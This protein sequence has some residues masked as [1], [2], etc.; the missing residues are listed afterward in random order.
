MPNLKDISHRQQFKPDSIEHAYR[1]PNLDDSILRGLLV[2][3]TVALA[4]GWLSMAE[5][6]RRQIE[7]F[8]RGEHGK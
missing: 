2:T 6:T 1:I 7:K 5:L 4:N 8:L 3:W